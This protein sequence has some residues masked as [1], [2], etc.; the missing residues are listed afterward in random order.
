MIL[1]FLKLLMFTKAI[2]QSMRPLRVNGLVSM[3]LDE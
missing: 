1:W 2:G 3:L